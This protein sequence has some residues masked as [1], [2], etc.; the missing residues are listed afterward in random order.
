M[1]FKS[2]FRMRRTH[3]Q[4]YNIKAIKTH[5]KIQ[6]D[7]PI[8]PKLAKPKQPRKPRKYKNEEVR[9]KR[10]IIVNAKSGKIYWNNVKILKEYINNI[11]NESDKRS[12]SNAL[13]RFIDVFRSK[14]VTNVKGVKRMR[15]YALDPLTGELR[16]DLKSSA[17]TG[18]IYISTVLAKIEVSNGND[19]EKMISNTGS[20][21]DTLARGLVGYGKGQSLSEY[22]Q[23]VNE[24]R[25]R[26][27][28]ENNW[29]Y[30]DDGS[31]YFFDGKNVYRLSWSYTDD[32]SLELVPKEGNGD[33]Y[34]KFMNK[35]RG[36]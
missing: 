35:A 32:F 13:D 4:T 25:S 12:M 16:S 18:D 28:N 23:E 6:Y 31:Q 17:A 10:R 26:L 3:T 30:S 27:I 15:R 7:K 5:S 9:F 14:G 24:M 21:V 19:I 36:S 22:S 20:S 11:P 33:I 2:K 34:E 1:K 8:T 29:V